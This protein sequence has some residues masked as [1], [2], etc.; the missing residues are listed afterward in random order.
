MRT[1]EQVAE[2]MRE[3]DQRVKRFAARMAGIH[4]EEARLLR[5][6]EE[7]RLWHW[8]GMVSLAAYVEARFGV[9][10][11]GG[12][13]DDVRDDHRHANVPGHCGPGACG[14]PGVVMPT[15]EALAV[16]AGTGSPFVPCR[17][18]RAVRA[19]LTVPG[20]GAGASAW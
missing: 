2:N 5:E 1:S 8:L 6:V 4:A 9:G 11:D 7:S 19:P 15:S 13:G 10:G 20:R 3:L 16:P 18:E 12:G 14:C 17:P